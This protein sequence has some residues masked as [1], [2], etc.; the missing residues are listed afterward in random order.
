MF[1]VFWHKF[2]EP[3]IKWAKL[4]PAKDAFD[5]LA[6]MKQEHPDSVGSACTWRTPRTHHA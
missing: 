1:L 4:I 6:K 3:R 5:A 2:G